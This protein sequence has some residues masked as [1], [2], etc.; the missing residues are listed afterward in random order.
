MKFAAKL[1]RDRIPEII[2]NSGRNPITSKLDSERFFEELYNKLD[3]EVLEVR[4][5]GDRDNLLEELSDVLEIIKAFAEA[6]GSNLK[7]IEELR[8]KKE[9]ER[10]GFKEKIYLEDIKD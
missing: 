10:G 5:A 3:E 6:Q 7:E 4:G 9:H 8:E 1:V 2:K